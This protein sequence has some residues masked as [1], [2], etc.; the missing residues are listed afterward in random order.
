MEEKKGNY[1]IFI[2]REQES[3]TVHFTNLSVLHAWLLDTLFSNPGMPVEQLFPLI[4]ETFKLEDLESLKKKI[5]SFLK[6][7]LE[8]GVILGFRQH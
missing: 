6:E 3:G 8:A 1:F 5:N 4:M 7:M 2:Y